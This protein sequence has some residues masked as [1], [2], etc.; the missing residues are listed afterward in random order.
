TD[1]K[2]LWAAVRA[3]RGEAEPA[4]RRLAEVG[5]EGIAAAAAAVV[6]DRAVPANGRA[7]AAWLCGATRDLATLPALGD[8]A[9][10]ETDPGLV[11]ACARALAALG[12]EDAREDLRSATK[13]A[14]ARFRRLSF[15][16]GGVPFH[17]LDRACRVL[18][19]LV[20]ALATVSKDPSLPGEI[21][22]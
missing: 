13:D 22:N 8:A 3:G 1:P 11:R 14:S 12:S 4:A 16:G 15:P 19:D 7:W 17:E 5:A 10:A 21:E 18:A 6:A 9:R 2:A 20:E